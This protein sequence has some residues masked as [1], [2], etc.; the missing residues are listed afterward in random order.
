M[1]AVPP[2]ANPPAIEVT[3]ELSLAR[4]FR[5]PLVAVAFAVVETC[6]STVAR[7]Q[8]RLSDPARPT[9]PAPAPPTVNDQIWA[10][11]GFA[12]GMA[13]LMPWLDEVGRSVFLSSLAS[14]VTSPV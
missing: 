13:L 2:P 12:D 7:I 8:L 3:V 9:V 1:P 5:L 10:S 6:A 14:T 11:S 4:T